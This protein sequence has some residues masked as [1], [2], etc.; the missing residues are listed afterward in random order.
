MDLEIDVNIGYTVA[1]LTTF[2]MDTKDISNEMIRIIMINETRQSL[3]I[4]RLTVEKCIS[5]WKIRGVSYG[6][7]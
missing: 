2:G 1:Y 7:K 6:Y 5:T 4:F 3:K